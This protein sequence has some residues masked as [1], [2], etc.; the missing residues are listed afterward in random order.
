ME[1]ISNWIQGKSAGFFDWITDLA[2]MVE[3]SVKNAII[4]ALNPLSGV[5]IFDGNSEDFDPTTPP[6]SGNQENQNGNRGSFARNPASVQE[7]NPTG[8]TEQPTEENNTTNNNYEVK[9]NQTIEQGAFQGLSND[10]IA[11][12]LREKGMTEGQIIEQ[13]RADGRVPD[14]R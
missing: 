14:G 10:E 12:V 4:N 3:N 13:L 7:P 9:V 2:N 5:D 1:S 11:Q 8:G 6:Y